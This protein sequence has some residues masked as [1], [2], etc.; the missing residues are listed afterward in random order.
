M[1][2]YMYVCMYVVMECMNVY[3][4][5]C[6]CVCVCV[7][8]FLAVCAHSVHIQVFSCTRVFPC[9]FFL[10]P[11]CVCT[12]VLVQLK[13]S[14]ALNVVS[15]DGSY[16]S[17]WEWSGVLFRQWKNSGGFLMCAQAKTEL[18]SVLGDMKV[19]LM[20]TPEVEPNP[21][22]IRELTTSIV[23]AELLCNL[24]L[25]VEAL[26]FEVSLARKG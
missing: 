13:T 25:H 8:I 5:V 10:Y 18:Y 23:D 6:V 16:W 2:V 24:V 19:I 4:Y 17:L 12:C 9:V 20:G 1:Y 22:T 7:H 3:M 14:G 26:E 15:S 21:D 11:W